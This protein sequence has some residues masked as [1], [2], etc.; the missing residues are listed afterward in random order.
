M[1]F[2]HIFTQYSSE[3]SK[4]LIHAKNGHDHLALLT[5]N[6]KCHYQFV[7]KSYHKTIIDGGWFNQYSDL[8]TLEVQYCTFRVGKIIVLTSI[9]SNN[10][11][12]YHINVT[13]KRKGLRNRLCVKINK[14]F[15]NKVTI[16]N[17][18]IKTQY[19]CKIICI[20]SVRYFWGF[21]I[22]LSTFSSFHL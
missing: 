6:M 3:F 9:N 12:I 10:C 5:L 1:V 13:L 7:A 19:T 8:A 15:I 4:G 11:I 16:T 14:K 17:N 20:A 22:Y 2:S 21:N 18:N